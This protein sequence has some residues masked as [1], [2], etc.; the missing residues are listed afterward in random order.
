[1]S[2]PPPSFTVITPCRN[3]VRHLDRCLDSIHAQRRDSL[4]VQH[5]VMDACSKDGT[6]ERLRARGDAIDILRSEPD[7]G[8]ADAINRALPLAEGEIVAWLNADDE[9][10]PHALARVGEAFS[11]APRAAFVFG[12]C[13]II[14]EQGLEIR[15]P[16]TRFKE[17]F[18]P[19]SS[20]F[21][22]QCINYLSQPAVFFRREAAKAAGPLRTDLRA[23][24]DYEFFLRL[25]RQG[26]GRHVMG[27]PLARFRWHEE[28]ISGRHFALQ[29]EEEY[30]A[31][32]ADA[33]AFSP[34]GIAH[35]F[36]KWGII[37][38]YRAMAS[39]RR[40]RA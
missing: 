20:R 23:A 32:V 34:Q 27:N 40:R 16:I 8:P 33:G 14:N 2:S 24:W 7:A 39:A 38:A 3:A 11:A 10:E 22:Y 35:L 28:S 18:F 5:I 26:G 6:L 31:A 15:R 21:T 29:F 37:A 13:P 30:R 19:L 17:L 4:R 9:Y 36:V 12:R 25:W 1:M